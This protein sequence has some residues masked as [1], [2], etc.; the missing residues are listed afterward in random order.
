[1]SFS[2]D[3]N[4]TS[5]LA[6]LSNKGNS[7]RNKALRAGKDIVVDNLEANTPYENSSD[8][9]WKG[10]REMDKIKGHKTIFNHMK[11]DIV[12]SGVNQKGGL[13]VGFGKD[14]YWRVHFVELGTMNMSANPFIER[15]LKSSESAYK[16]AV[17]DTVRK[18]LDL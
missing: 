5:K 2:I 11:D 17:E 16:S 14:T 8:R 6:C 7:I 10:Q 18:E 4:I 13:K 15:T 1:M 9:S 3:D 12:Y